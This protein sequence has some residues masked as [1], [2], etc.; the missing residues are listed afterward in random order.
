[1]RKAASYSACVAGTVPLSWSDTA[2]L[3]QDD[4]QCC[5]LEPTGRPG[6]VYGQVPGNDDALS[7]AFRPLVGHLLAVPGGCLRPRELADIVEDAGETW[8][9]AARPIRDAAP[10]E[11]L[12]KVVAVVNGLGACTEIVESGAAI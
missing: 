10:R 6:Y 1:M 11:H 7:G 9:H 4:T 2:P 5:A 8:A 3:G 12:A